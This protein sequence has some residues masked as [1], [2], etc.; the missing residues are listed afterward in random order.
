MASPTYA[1]CD[2]DVVA[3]AWVRRH[4]EFGKH[5]DRPDSN[6]TRDERAVPRTNHRPPETRSHVER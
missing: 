1:Y 2:D 4:S 3:G 6:E 5:M